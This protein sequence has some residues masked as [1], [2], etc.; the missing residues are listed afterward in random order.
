[1]IP[2]GFWARRIESASTIPGG[3]GEDP[4]PEDTLTGT[5]RWADF[6]GNTG[7]GIL[8]T[9]ATEFD[10]GT[11]TWLEIEWKDGNGFPMDL[12]G[13]VIMNRART[14]FRADVGNASP[15]TNPE[16]FTPVD[17]L[18]EFPAGQPAPLIRVRLQRGSTV[19]DFTTGAWEA[20][21][22]DYFDPGFGPSFVIP[23]VT[24]GY[25][26]PMNSSFAPLISDAVW[27]G[28]IWLGGA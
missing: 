10:P 3:G 18:L 25:V 23:G 9:D 16:L 1:M 12:G 8:A 7:G 13:G 27:S 2:L 19:I 17:F 22:S 26:H 4:P 14:I 20:T 11:V 21:S 5:P 24:N 15:F 28:Q 6:I